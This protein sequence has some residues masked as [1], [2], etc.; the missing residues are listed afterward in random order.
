MPGVWLA[1]RDA[2]RGNNFFPWDGLVKVP[3]FESPLRD[4]RL[5]VDLPPDRLIERLLEGRDVVTLLQ[6]QKDLLPPGSSDGED[7]RSRITLI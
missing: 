7:L 3:N 5:N 2:Q 4:Q 6:D 1:Q